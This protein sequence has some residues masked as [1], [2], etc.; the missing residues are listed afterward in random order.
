MIAKCPFTAGANKNSIF[1]HSRTLANDLARARQYGRGI[2][3]VAH[4]LGAIIV[5]EVKKVIVALIG[6]CL[7]LSLLPVTNSPKN[8][9]SHEI[10]LFQL[11]RPS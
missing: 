6:T 11:N 3:F 10:N 5:K 9:H 2:V 7:S 1:T 8:D 4:S